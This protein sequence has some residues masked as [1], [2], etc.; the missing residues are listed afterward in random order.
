M[1]L[2][3]F[4]ASSE[5]W[6]PP[7]SLAKM[8]ASTSSMGLS[9]RAATAAA[10][11]SF[12]DV[13]LPSALN[14]RRGCMS[15][16]AC[17]TQPVPIN[18]TLYPAVGKGICPPPLPSS[19]HPTTPSPISRSAGQLTLPCCCSLS[20]IFPPSPLQPRQLSLLTLVAV[21][22]W[23]RIRRRT[24]GATTTFLGRISSPPANVYQ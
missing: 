1:G 8:H 12:P 24:T 2:E 23:E 10:D 5:F 17:C 19:N 15:P 20:S 22:P 11:Y 6:N 21:K 7:S 16:D 13:Q 4:L 3:V 14:C 9:H 18:Y